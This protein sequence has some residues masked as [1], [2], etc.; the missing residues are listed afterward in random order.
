MTPDSRD[1]LQVSG[2]V[3]FRRRGRGGR[4]E[5]EAGDATQSVPAG[6][7]PRVARLMALAIRYEALLRTGAVA[8]H[9][10][11]AR[12]GRVTRARVTQVLNLLHLAPDLQ[13]RLLFLP[14]ATSGR[15]GLL[16]RELQAIS[17]LP[18]WKNQRSAFR[19]LL[20]S[21]GRS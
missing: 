10:E 2:T 9:A 20:S 18:D 1:P 5:L 15:D 8:N 7:I 16:L 3:R 11:L 6:R 19:E 21:R 14:P 4:V 17:R 12:R 13:E